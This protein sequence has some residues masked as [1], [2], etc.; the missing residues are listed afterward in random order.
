MNPFAELNP[1]Y[2]TI[3]ADPPWRYRK[4]PNSESGN[5]ERRTAED[6]Y[7]TM[8]IR[9]IA[10]LPVAGLAADNACLFLWTTNP[11]IFGDRNEGGTFTAFDV[12]SAW[13]FEYRTLLT[14][15]KTGSPG[16]GS[17]FRGD[18]EHVLFGIRGEVKIEPAKRESNVIT[19]AKSGHSRKPAA[20]MDL[21]ERVVPGPYL[22]LFCRDPR[23]GWDS[24]GKG[25]EGAA[26]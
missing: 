3:V 16:M 6:N 20:F 13:G 15:V 25:Y 9:D 21:V 26:A 14:W 22:D 11:R 10:A 24:W 8:A 12:M 7:S 4:S 2:S 18:T 17:Y 1:P 5:H 19:A 23:F